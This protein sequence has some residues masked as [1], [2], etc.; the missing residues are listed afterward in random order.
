LLGTA[1]SLAVYCA[2]KANKSRLE[3]IDKFIVLSSHAKQV[4]MEQLGLGDS[5]FVV[6]PNFYDQESDTGTESPDGLPED[7]ILFVGA[8]VPAKGVDV[9]IEAYR[10]LGTETKLV[11]IGLKHPRYS[12]GGGKGVVLIE[13]APRGL[14][15]QAYDN[16][17]FAVFPS[18]WPESSSTVMLEAM[19]SKKAIVCSRVGGLSEVV[20]DGETGVL[21]P[22][23]DAEMLS[24]AISYLLQNPQVA[25]SMGQRGYERW[26]Q[27]FTADAVTMEIEKL[28]ESLLEKSVV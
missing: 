26:R 10:K 17:R 21:V 27:L 15:L 9:L 24:E 8:L 14:V 22:P 7:F 13:N 23:G 11:V 16:C 28:Y 6:I 3:L 1:K 19:A 18:T 25:G 12:Y 4:H 20:E 5:R 2:T